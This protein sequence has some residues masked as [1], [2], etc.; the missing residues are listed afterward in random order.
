MILQ[1]EAPMKT[2]W[3]GG[4]LGAAVGFMKHPSFSIHTVTK[5][6]HM[7]CVESSHEGQPSVTSL[8][9]SL[10]GKFGFQNC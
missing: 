10:Y 9:V 2:S 6:V 3:L 1:N 8:T 7:Y 5:E 4:F